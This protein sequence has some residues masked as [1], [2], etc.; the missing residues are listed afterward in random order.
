MELIVTL[1]LASVC[2]LVYM[3]ARRRA[4]PK[5]VRIRKDSER[6]SA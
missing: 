2:V 4:E 1:A 5:M 6:G 3:L